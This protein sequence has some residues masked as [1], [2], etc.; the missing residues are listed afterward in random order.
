MSTDLF[1]K[2]SDVYARYR[3]QY[4]ASFYE[5]IF[6]KVPDFEC[7]WDCATGNGQAAVALAQKFNRVIATDLSS[8][9]LKNAIPNP[10]VEYRC[11]PSEKT[12]LAD[13]SVSLITVAQAAHWFQFDD[14]YREVNRVL[15]PGGVLAIF[16]YSFFTTEEPAL[17]KAVLDFS[18]GTLGS[19]WKPQNRL[20]WDGYR[21]IPFPFE[22]FQVSDPKL[23]VEMNFD[24][25]M[26][27]VRSWSATQLYRDQHGIDPVIE[28]EKQVRAL[29]KEPEKRQRF[30][31]DLVRRLGR[32]K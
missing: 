26:G 20:L 21:D 19:Y 1:S 25:M 4:P 24:E 16:G 7:A 17:A 2:Q 9:Q 14:F 30:E 13:Q 10:R 12:T 29:W 22:E 11:E 5:A 6:A 32:K 15:K 27:Y 28:F 31:W 23:S 3:P 18:M 8:V